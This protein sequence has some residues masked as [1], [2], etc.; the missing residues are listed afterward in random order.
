VKKINSIL[1][2]QLAGLGDMVL[3]TPALSALRS[4]YFQAKVV[5]LTNSRSVDIVRGSKDLDEIFILDNL[6]D[7]LKLFRKLRS[8]HFDLVINLY[9]LYS[10]KGAIKMFLLFLSIG[11]EYWVGRDTAA[12]GFFYHLRVPEKL[13]D[14]KHEVEHKLDIIRALGGQ[15]KEMNL[16]V[17]FDKEDEDFIKDLLKKEGIEDKDILIGINCATFRPSRNWTAVGYAQLAEQLTKKMSVKVAFCGGSLDR[18]IFN[19]IKFKL[20]VEV[21]DLVGKLTVRQLI[22]FIKRCNLFISPDSGPMHIAAVLGVPL[23][24]LFGEE[25]YNEFRPFGDEK[26]IKIIRTPMKLINPEQV[27][28]TVK[29]LLFKIDG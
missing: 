18:K 5:L 26:L 22:T 10:F 25:E 14:S 3:A 16:K 8:Y 7:F 4:L 20:S 24:S 19:K 21:L 9:R 13:N 1:V 6:S 15:I 27:I 2:I 17:E 12:R 11:G 28:T 29:Q 23:V